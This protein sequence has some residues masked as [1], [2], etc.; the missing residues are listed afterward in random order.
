MNC[1]NDQIST[2]KTF[3]KEVFQA[4]T[5]ILTNGSTMG[6]GMTADAPEFD[7]N[8]LRLENSTNG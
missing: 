7:L 1:G 5:F 2:R 4:N 3:G 6:K 8:D